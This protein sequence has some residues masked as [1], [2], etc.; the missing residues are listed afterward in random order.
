MDGNSGGYSIS[1]TCVY[2]WPITSYPY[3]SLCVKSPIFKSPVVVG[4]NINQSESSDHSSATSQQLH[5]FG[6]S[7]RWQIYLAKLDESDKLTCGDNFHNLTFSLR[8]A[9]VPWI[10]DANVLD[11]IRITSGRVGFSLLVGSGKE[12]EVRHR[13]EA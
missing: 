10:R 3:D 5:R 6:D 1:A 4:G 7:I 11:S 8:L 2:D 13:R 9:N 12:Q